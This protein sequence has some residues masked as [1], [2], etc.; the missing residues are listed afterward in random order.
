MFYC[1][2]QNDMGVLQ[3]EEIHIG[4]SLQSRVRQIKSNL[5]ALRVVLKIA[6]ILPKIDTKCDNVLIDSLTAIPLT[7]IHGSA[8]EDQV[9]TSSFSINPATTA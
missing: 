3:R 6:R 8:R 7:S 2:I 9:R 5:E 4:S 1:T